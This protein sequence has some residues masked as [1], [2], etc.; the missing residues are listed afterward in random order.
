M[1]IS[2]QVN[3]KGWLSLCYHY[4]R[5]SKDIDKFQRLLGTSE[6][7]F[8]EHT[9][10]LQQNFQMISLQEAKKLCEGKLSLNEKHGMLMTF[11]DGL[12]DHYLAA[13]IL[14]Q[15]DIK[16]TFFIPTGILEDQLPATPNII[17]YCLA[18]FGIESFIDVFNKALLF[19]QLKSENFNLAFNKK[20]D[21]Q[22]ETIKKIKLIFKYKLGHINARKIAIYIYENLLLPKYPD[23]LNIM[24][25]TE[26]QIK[27]ML[28]M[29]HSI[30]V[31]TRS[32][33]SVASSN[34][35]L[36]DFNKEVVY[37]KKFLE[38]TFDTEIIAFAYPF[39]EKEDCLES[40][41]L[42]ERT[43]E[44]QMAFTVEKIVNK[45]DTSTFELGRYSPMST[46]DSFNLHR[47][48]KNIIREDEMI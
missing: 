48:L 28:E 36:S 2:N 34:L 17:H 45:I 20:N 1:D 21:D 24:H 19:Y 35:S 29:G 42:L 3:S 41:K 46:D 13:K 9:K 33:V 11:D 25:L 43:N 32:H 5:P 37:P 38:K 6:A 39:G 40:K 26:N 47:I 18:D 16:A 31:H 14:N 7:E 12:S 44:Y 23:I 15:Y 8:H 4:I 22:W 30:G 27:E 10:I